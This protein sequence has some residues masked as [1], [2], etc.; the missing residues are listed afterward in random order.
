MLVKVVP[1]EKTFDFP[2]ILLCVYEA[3]VLSYDNSKKC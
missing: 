2:R 1:D 3:R